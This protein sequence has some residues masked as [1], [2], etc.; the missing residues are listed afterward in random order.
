MKFRKKANRSIKVKV[1][2]ARVPWRWAKA[3]QNEQE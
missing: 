2:D 1:C 3:T